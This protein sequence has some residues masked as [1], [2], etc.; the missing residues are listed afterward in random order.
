MI[1]E[2]GH[3]TIL[4]VNFNVYFYQEHGKMVKTPEAQIKT[5]SLISKDFC[6]VVKLSF[7]IDKK[8]MWLHFVLPFLRH[9]LGLNTKSRLDD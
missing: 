2:D 1:S 3:E 9:G 7:G 6:Y 5:L 8:L 4:F